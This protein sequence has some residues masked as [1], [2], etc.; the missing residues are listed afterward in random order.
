MITVVC[1]VNQCPYISKNG[2]CRNRLVSINANGM[3][4]HLYNQKGQ[5]KP[6]WNQ[7]VDEMFKDAV[8]GQ[9]MQEA[10]VKIQESR[11]E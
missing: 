11:Q 5:V 6:H 8:A 4:G 2:F 9:K 7:P 10:R 1:K 3:C